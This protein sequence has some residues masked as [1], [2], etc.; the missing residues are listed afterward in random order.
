VRALSFKKGLS[1]AN[2]DNAID[3][4]LLEERSPAELKVLEESL[5]E[6]P[7][8]LGGEEKRR[9]L[10]QLQG[11][12]LSSDAFFPFRDNIDRA[13]RSG[14]KYVLQPGGSLRDADIIEAADEY[15]MVM[16]LSG[17]RLFHH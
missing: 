5:D 9:W 12:S 14:V 2:R 15:G 8:P 4:F 1:R 6:I 10:G 13:A 11:V 17:V 3:V 16:A 7:Q